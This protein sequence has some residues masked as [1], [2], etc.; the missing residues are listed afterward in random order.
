MNLKAM[1]SDYP[2]RCGHREAR[3]GK[4]AGM[5]VCWACFNMKRSSQHKF[6]ADNLRYL[7]AKA[8]AKRSS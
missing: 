2:C 5:Y 3:H 4:M 1:E 7:E 6:L 8:S